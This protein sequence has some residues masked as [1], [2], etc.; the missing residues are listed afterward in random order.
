MKSLPIEELVEE[1]KMMKIT[2]FIISKGRIEESHICILD[3]RRL[4]FGELRR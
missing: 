1:I 2:M 3:F 4:K